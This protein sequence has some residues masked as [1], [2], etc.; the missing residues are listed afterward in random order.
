MVNV[1]K[2]VLRYVNP[3]DTVRKF[4]IIDLVI[5]LNDYPSSLQFLFTSIHFNH[6]KFDTPTVVISVIGFPT[7]LVLRVGVHLFVEDHMCM[8]PDNK[9]VFFVT[10]RL[11]MMLYL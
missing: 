7:L 10:S 9:G 5:L 1:M 6:N 8:L 11:C 4:F 3:T 2:F